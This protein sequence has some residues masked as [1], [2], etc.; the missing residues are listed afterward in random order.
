MR[1]G[2]RAACG[3][4]FDKLRVNGEQVNTTATNHRRMRE[5]QSPIAALTPREFTASPA[6]TIGPLPDQRSR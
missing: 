4:P 6:S 2:F 5:I 1:R 3:W